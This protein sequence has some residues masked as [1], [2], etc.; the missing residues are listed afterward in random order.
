[1]EERILASIAK[2]LNDE[3]KRTVKDTLEASIER[4]IQKA[5]GKAICD[6]EFY[7]TMSNDLQSGL[8]QL[9]VEMQNL[10]KEMNIKTCDENASPVDVFAHTADKLEEIYSK[11]EDATF[12]VMNIVENQINNIS[13]LK[14]IENINK[15]NLDIFLDNINDS[16]FSILTAL[17]FQ[18]IIGQQ[19]KK[20]IIFIKNIED[21]INRLYISQNM[22]LKSKEENP[23]LHCEV[24]K[25]DVEEKISQETIDSLLSEYGIE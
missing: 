24:I 9:M 15:S 20:V 7:Q 17:S 12:S 4:E 23:D 13:D 22:M 25:K 1:M 18:D 16:M 3:I 8:N 11:T 2:R 10:K 6:G 21:M 19:I 14:D 5:L